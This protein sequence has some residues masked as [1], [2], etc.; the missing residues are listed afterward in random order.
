MSLTTEGVRT[1]GG[2]WQE[3]PWDLRVAGDHQWLDFDRSRSWVLNSHRHRQ[4]SLSSVGPEGRRVRSAPRRDS[5]VIVQWPVNFKCDR[6]E[7]HTR[8]FL[9]KSS[10][11]TLFNCLP[12]RDRAYPTHI[13]VHRLNQLLDPSPLFRRNEP[14]VQLKT[15]LGF[16]VAKEFWK[17]R[18]T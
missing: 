14:L 9:M 17:I 3:G 2:R 5:R 10:T 6:M 16:P 18:P 4:R 15:R 11:S 8:E 13:L 7:S 1:P 12:N